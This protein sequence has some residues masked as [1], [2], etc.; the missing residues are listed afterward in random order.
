MSEGYFQ[1]VLEIVRQLI[2]LCQRSVLV[3][4]SEMHAVSTGVRAKS[5]RAA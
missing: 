3:R 1:L 2:F 4:S 5:P